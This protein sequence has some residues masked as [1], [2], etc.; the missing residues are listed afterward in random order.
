MA[1][2]CYNIISRSEESESENRENLQELNEENVRCLRERCKIKRPDYFGIPVAMQADNSE[3]RSYEEAVSSDDTEKWREAM[4]E[5]MD[6]LLKNETWDL[7][8]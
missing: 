7:V 3:P 2:T 1:F 5:E 4:D 6:S 8:S